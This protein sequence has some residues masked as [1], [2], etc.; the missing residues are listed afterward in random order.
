M[1]RQSL[2]KLSV[3]L[4]TF[5]IG[6]SLSSIWGAH[7]TISLC[8]LDA[9]PSTYGDKTVRFRA[10]VNN[11]QNRITAFSVCGSSCGAPAASIELGRREVTKFP[12]PETFVPAGGG[13]NQVY[14]MDAV[15]VGRLDPHFRASC[16]TP[17]RYR[18]SDAR[19]ERVFSI[20]DFKDFPQAMKWAE[21][22]S[23]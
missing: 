9:D 15:I 4:A 5:V 7:H 10:I 23:Y 6:L 19:V 8:E 16:F 12:L 20:Q 13:G 1:V 17:T 2:Y 14:L 11:T 21:S 18:V 22:N 3:G